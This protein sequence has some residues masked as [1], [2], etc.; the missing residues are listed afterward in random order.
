[1]TTTATTAGAVAGVDLL[2]SPLAPPAAAAP[3]TAWLRIAATAACALLIFVFAWLYRFNDPGGSFAFLTDDHFFYLV[4]GWQI[5]YGEL[6]VR[7]FVDHGAPLYY[8]VS[9]G[10]QW[11]FGRGTLSE[12]AFSVT[13][14][15]AGAVGV[16]LLS[17]RAAGS[18]V[19]ALLSTGI[20]VLLE[21]RLYNYPK[22]LVYAAAIPA[23]WAFADRP[24]RRR[25]A[26]LAVVTVVGFLFRHDHGA[27]VGAA[28]VAMLLMR[29]GLTWPQRARL[30]AAYALV[31]VI[32]VAPYLIFIE[33]HGGVVLYFRTAVE[34]SAHDRGRADVVWPGLRDNPDGMSRLARTGRPSERMVATIRDNAVA[35]LYYSELAVPILALIVVGLLPPGGAA[36]VPM[37]GEKIAVVAIL[38]LLTDAGFL[39]A[40]LAARLADPS[41]PIVLLIAWLP[42]A[43]IAWIRLPRGRSR[44]LI[45]SVT[46]WLAVATGFALV[47]IVLIAVTRD[48][49][50]RLE[51]TSLAD[52]PQAAIERASAMWRSIGASFPLPRRPTTRADNLLTL[53]VYLRECTR[54]TDRV[55]VQDYLPQVIALSERGFAG[56][57][58]DLRPGFFESDAMQWLAVSRLRRQSVPIAILGGGPHLGGF[59]DAF[60]IVV[61][62]FDAQYRTAG[63][64][65]FDGRFA[66]RVLVRRDLRPVRRFEPLGLPCFR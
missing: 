30:G 25:A 55:F 57:L 31:A 62:Y 1:V 65:T 12:I 7:D 21:P 15:A 47:A 42:M 60:P 2:P 43:L 20:Y 3:R 10:V 4:R 6:P 33:R 28:F 13:L 54:P 53:A 22:I 34:W 59:R 32:L 38:G 26:L 50:S 58:A 36:G 8:Y 63:E 56:G 23:L 46:G 18:I 52:G 29:R 16:F 11:R 41:V 5:L 39:R 27:F 9:A 61:S 40:P 44:P 45:A 17:A 19:T 49:R 14:L 48:T 24:D 37:A 64:R 35:W 51:K 66:V